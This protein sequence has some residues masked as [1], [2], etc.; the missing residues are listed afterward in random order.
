MRA[1]L[2]SAFVCVCVC[3]QEFFDRAWLGVQLCVGVNFAIW[4]LL[5][6]VNLVRPMSVQ[7]L[8]VCGGVRVRVHFLSEC[9]CVCV[10]DG[11]LPWLWTPWWQQRR[12]QSW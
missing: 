12:Q 3:V 2:A 4:T 8:Y 6:S 10:W 1:K 11:V 7:H 9:V 5:N